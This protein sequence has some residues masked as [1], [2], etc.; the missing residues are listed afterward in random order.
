MTQKIQVPIIAEKHQE[1]EKPEYLFWVG[2]MGAFDDRYQKVT[3]AFVKILH[4]LGVDYAVLGT[5]EVSSGD[6]ARRA[7]NE[8]LF[9]MQAMQNIELFEQYGVQKIITCDP[10]AF[11]TF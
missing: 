1:G 8:M 3:R 9:Q 6:A 10:H 7:G 4:H 2:S 11:N 5:E